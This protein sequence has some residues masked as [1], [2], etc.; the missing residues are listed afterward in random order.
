MNPD[1][2]GLYLSG[3]ENS[4]RSSKEIRALNSTICKEWDNPY[5]DVTYEDRIEEAIKRQEWRDKTDRIPEQAVVTI[6]SDKPIAVCNLSDVHIGANKVDYGYLKYITDT[7]KENDNAFCVLGGDLC[8]TISW[9]NGQNDDILS[10]QDQHEMMYAMLSQLRGKI[11]AGVMGNHN[12]EERTWVSKYQEYL[13]TADA[14]LFDNIGW[15]ELRIDNN[16]KLIPYYIAMAHQLKGYSIYNPNHPQKSFSNGVEGC[17]VIMSAHTHTPGVQSQNKNVF[18][19]ETKGLTFIN[20]M[21]LK[22]NDKFL[23]GKGNPNNPIGANWLYL[24]CNDKRH[25]AIPNT[26]IAKE[27]M[28]WDM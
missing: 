24:S 25:F 4:F 17:D 5:E 19:G 18:G 6:K 27:V 7:I 3:N 8:D 21:S 15:L 10:F 2:D 23:R 9:N 26:E 14:P 28:G 22:K 20:G 1:K 12:W 13:R 16:E 11:I